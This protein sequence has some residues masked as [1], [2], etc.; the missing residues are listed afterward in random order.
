MNTKDNQRARLTRMLLKQAYMR[1]MNEKQTAKISV[2]DICEKA[3]VN[4]S[5]FYLHYSEPNAILMELE[6]ETIALVKD[7]LFSIGAMESESPDAPDRLLSFL[8]YVQRND[9]LFRTFL[10][11]NSDPHFR[12]KLLE[13]ALRMT[14]T[15]FRVELPPE[16]KGA[17]YLFIVS[18]CL[19]VLTSWI[20]AGF[21]LPEQTVCALLYRLSEGALREVC[22][23]PPAL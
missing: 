6:D 21:T 1:L 2:K 11:E 3:E 8:H 19:E 14:E 18:G 12:R 9:E 13:V 23:L 17:V 15:S 22:M 16:R 7:A 5:T 10:V 4:R 20:R